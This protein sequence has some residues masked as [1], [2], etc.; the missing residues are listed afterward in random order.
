MAFIVEMCWGRSDGLL[1]YGLDADGELV[2]SHYIPSSTP[3]DPE[4][5][6]FNCHMFTWKNVLE[7]G[8]RAG[9]VPQGTIP[10]DSSRD[11]WAKLGRFESSY[12]PEEW[13]YAKQFR[14]DDAASLAD[15]LQRVLDSGAGQEVMTSRPMPLLLRDGMSLEEI[16]DANRNIS[17]VFLR[18][19]IAFIRKGCFVF[20]WDD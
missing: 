9:W 6:E 8:E 4:R 19:F 14:A 1:V 11:V 2:P 20:A 15:A 7:L 16:I 18:D 13:Q 10:T 3:P 12:K 17:P 5:R